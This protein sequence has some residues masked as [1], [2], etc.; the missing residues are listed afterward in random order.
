MTG[1]NGL[2]ERE[3]GARE[4]IDELIAGLGDW[5][6]RTLGD[7]RRVIR[8]ADPEII[9]EW[10]WRGA[11]VWAHGGIVC[12]GN[13]FKDKVKLT[14][15]EGAAIA[16]PDRLYNNGL[17]GNKWRTID[18]FEDDKVRERELKN[19]VRAAVEYNLGKGK[20]RGKA[21]RKMARSRS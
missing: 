6:G 11:P 12:M 20:G 9:E 13:A 15:Y 4:R 1:R 5:R 7:I 17:A 18:F 2:L 3:M 14:F 16:D 8:A 19:L 10:K 21:P